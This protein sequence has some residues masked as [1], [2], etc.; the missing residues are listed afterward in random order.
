MNKPGNTH[1]SCAVSKMRSLASSSSNFM[2]P[3]L[4]L[5]FLVSLDLHRVQ[6]VKP[7]LKRRR[8]QLLVR[9]PNGLLRHTFSAR[10]L[11]VAP[12]G[13]HR[14]ALEV[15]ASDAKASRFG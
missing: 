7:F 10:A 5:R 8:L 4:N 12:H 1:K 13:V 3:L 2:R 15:I 6:P 14:L 11:A 9:T